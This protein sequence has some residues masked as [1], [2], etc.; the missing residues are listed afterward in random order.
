MRRWPPV[1]FPIVSGRQKTGAD[2]RCHRRPRF[3]PA[4][5][6]NESAAQSAKPVSPVSED[7]YRMQAPRHRHGPTTVAAPAVFQK[8]A[9]CRKGPSPQASRYRNRDAGDDAGSR[10]PEDAACLAVFLLPAILPGNGLRPQQ[11]ARPVCARS[12]KAHRQT[13]QECLT[14]RQSQPLLNCG[15]N[16]EKARRRQCH[17]L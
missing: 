14:D 1:P 13:V 5:R 15:H 2:G 10:R 6:Q 12:A 8:A 4:S 9:G 3:L 17:A 7:V 16:R 11:P